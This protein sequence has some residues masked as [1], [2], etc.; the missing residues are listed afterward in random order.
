MNACTYPS[1]YL[2]FTTMILS[3]KE[4]DIFRFRVGGGG[5]GRA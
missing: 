5:K 3:V 1:L 2:G 4:G